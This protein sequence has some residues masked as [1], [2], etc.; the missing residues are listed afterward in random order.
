MPRVRRHQLNRLNAEI[1][2]VPYI[3]VMLVLLV[4]FMVTAPLLTQGI[5]VNLPK[6]QG[7]SLSVKE[8]PIIVS[9]DAYGRYYLNTNRKPG[10]A[11][12]AQQLMSQVAS[13]M[14]RKVRKIY[15]KGDQAVNYGKVMQAIALI[16][17]AGGDQV[18]LITKTLSKKLQ[19]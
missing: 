9:V 5:K 18:G 6:A 15:V 1:N 11:I 12:S 17:K 4:I 10:K 16:K 14:Q 3:D 2:V 7:K 19:S 13:L 8:Q